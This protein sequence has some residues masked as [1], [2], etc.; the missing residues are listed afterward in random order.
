M[1]RATVGLLLLAGCQPQHVMNPAAPRPTWADFVAAWP[2]FK[3]AILAGTIAGAVLGFLG[4]FILVRRMVFVSATLTQASGLGV[5]LAFYAHIHLGT[6]VPPLAGALLAALG[7]SF[8]AS[9]PYERLHLSRESALATLWL[10]ASSGAVIVGSRITQE[11]HDIAGIL[12]G[13]AVLVSPEDLGMVA[14][15]GAVGLVLGFLGHEVLVFSGFDADAA[16][17]QGVPVR[18]FESA[19]LMLV[20]AEVAV[21]TRAIGALPVFAFSVLPAV[22]ALLVA[23]G[24]RLAFPLATLF[25]A[26]AGLGGY[27]L[28]FFFDLPVGAT[29]TA[30][31]VLLVV[32]ATPLRWLRG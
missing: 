14:A 31:A 13:S 6:D 3:E 21:A 12:F 27:M 8:L 28:A 17:V 2:L 4:V 22:A 20:T 29:Q 25:G 24:M 26:S 32:A 16:R 23:P 5:A 10:F 7:A 1:G 9:L 19:L 15:V 18:V 30:L 11:A